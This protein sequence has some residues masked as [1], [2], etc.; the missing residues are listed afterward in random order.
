MNVQLYAAGKLVYDSLLPEEANR[1]AMSI[2]L[3]ESINK[4]GT[5]K[6]ILP[7]SNPM[8]DALQPFC[9]P[10]EIYRDGK[11]RW[12][13]RP[14]TPAEDFYN[15]KTIICEG[16]MCFLQ[17]AIHRPYAYNA[18]P[19]IVFKQVVGVYNAA[20]EQ[21]KRFTVGTVTVSN[22]GKNVALESQNP[23]NVLE[24]IQ[25]LVEIC[26]GYILF[27]SAPDGSRRINWYEDLPYTCTQP[28][29]YGYNLTGYTRQS[30]V[31]E[32]ATR[33][34]PYGA[35]D[36]NGN[37]IKLDIGGKD[38]VQNDE[39]VALHG[40][41]E[42]SVIYNDV[43][44]SAELEAR[45]KADVAVSGL[46]PS[47]IQLSAIDM[48]RQ[49]LAMDPF[50]I[51]QRVPAESEQHKLSGM[52][53]LV[54][55]YEDLVNPSVGS[56]TLT[57]ELA[58]LSGGVDRTLTG[59]ILVDRKS[60][61]SSAINY[62]DSAAAHAVASQTQAQIFNKLTNG[63]KVKGIY[64]LDDGQLYINASYIKSGSIVSEGK[65]YLPPTYDDV[66]EMLW[67]SIFPDTYPPK[68]FYDLN[69]DG[70]LDKDDVL[71]AREIYLG[72]RDISECPGVY[73]TD[74]TVTIEPSNAQAAVLIS[75]INMWGSEI[76]MSLG[77]N[78]SK[79]PVISGDCSVQ[80][81]LAVGGCAIMQSLSTEVEQTP[82]ALSWKDN[83]DGTYT[84]IGT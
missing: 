70:K 33:I 57:R 3:D 29:K 84:L 17:D 27:D 37:R 71:L 35:P 5:A 13:G 14:L 32:F 18:D 81:K 7:S 73:K 54:R 68:D 21:W 4:G 74:V 12:R 44:T 55:L 62:A 25:T 79:I 36:E 47:V 72:N 23:E 10:V 63:G 48:S 9:V 41:I 8:S 75:G 31:S 58:S 19:A 30:D 39:A 40:V 2:A 69:G 67:S 1:S 77:A 49:D 61:L 15:S 82:K 20:V 76:T 24:V 45:A 83:G 52:Y 26:G 43:T 51:G 46:I 34:I 59:A 11:L 78:S 16:E 65:A 56:I 42:R 53:S 28:V 60:L 64:M 22:G 6:I 50:M 80:G 38:Y 66:I